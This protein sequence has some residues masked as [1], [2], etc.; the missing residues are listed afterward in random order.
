MSIIF[1]D[2]D[3]GQEKLIEDYLEKAVGFEKFRDGWERLRTYLKEIVPQI[4]KSGIKIT[5]I[6]GTNG[7]GETSTTLSYLLCREGYSTALW[8]SPHVLSIRERMLF[9]MNPLSYGE[10]FQLIQKTHKKAA[11]LGIE[12][13]Y[14]ELL[15]CSFLEQV[16]ENHQEKKIDHLILEVGMGGRLDAVNIFDSHL[17]AI[18][19]ISRDHQEFLGNSYQ[20]ILNEKMGIMRKNSPLIT[21]FEL[22]FLRDLAR[23][24]AKEMDCEFVDLFDQQTL[25]SSDHYSVRNRLLALTLLRKIQ[26][27]SLPTKNDLEGIAFPLIK[28]RSEVMTLGKS[29]FIFVGSHN[30][31]GIRKLIDSVND[32]NFGSILVAFSK[33]SEEREVDYLLKMFLDCRKKEVPLYITDFDH[34]KAFKFD[35]K[36]IEDLTKSERKVE[37]VNDWKKLLTENNNEEKDLLVTGSF[38]FVGA[39]QNFLLEKGAL[40]S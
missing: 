9:N 24:R 35:D 3:L 33:R 32:K 39:V 17:T 13:S 29:R 40:L 31:D 1:S 18:T 2:V 28:G 4:Q 37:Y 22:H 14:Y 38:Y 11:S 6:A 12:F 7:K 23:K 26:N 5:T 36:R 20:K 15:L 21:T 25:S 19:S 34:F 10:F 27:Q 8:L 16:L 30:L